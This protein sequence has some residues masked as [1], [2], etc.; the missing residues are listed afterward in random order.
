VRRIKEES[1]SPVAMIMITGCGNERIVVEAVREGVHGYLP[2]NQ[3]TAQDVASAI[4]E[5]L[6]RAELE[7]EFARAWQRLQRL[8]MFDTLTNLPN[9]KLFL[10]RLDSRPG[11]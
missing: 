9:R 2:K 11:H 1:D 4:E 8:S 5:S 7:A 6:R 10:E 3:L